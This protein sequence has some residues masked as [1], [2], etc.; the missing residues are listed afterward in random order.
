MKRRQFIRYAGASLLAA[1]GAFV[2]SIGKRAFGQSR[3]TLTVTGLG[4][5]C[6]LFV[7]GGLRV[8]VNPFRAIGCTQGYPVP[9]AEA[10]LVLISSQLF[11]EGA[12]EDLP[13]NPQI[14]FEPGVF[15]IRN[16][17][18]QGIE[19]ERIR[20]RG[21]RFS[22]N[23]A[24]RWTQAGVNILHLGGAAAPIEIE[25]QILMGRPDLALIPVGGGP[26]AYRPEEA[27]QALRALR[28]KMVVPT[29]Y[30]TRAADPDACNLVPVETFLQ[31]AGEM[32][33][34]RVGSNRL[35]LSPGNFNREETVIRVLQYPFNS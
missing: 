6:F 26:K 19:S 25:Q 28:P 22:T 29:H 16:T 12:T 27:M 34:A 13:G 3:G 31:L 18:F 24:W 32:P 8:L 20:D 7:G 9:R 1:G 30:R 10:D 23:V 33:V 15:E 14:L 2:P 5:T 21:R 35:N 17:Q 11:D 4:H